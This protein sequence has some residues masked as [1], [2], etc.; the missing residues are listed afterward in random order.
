VDGSSG[1]DA[2]PGV[3]DHAL[4]DAFAAAVRAA[5]GEEADD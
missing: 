5:D 2:S 4:I 1:A 3:K